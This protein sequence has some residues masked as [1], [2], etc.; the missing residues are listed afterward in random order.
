MLFLA[1]EFVY[2]NIMK[3]YYICILY[4]IE[5][6]V[7]F[8]QLYFIL[9]LI[10]FGK[11]CL[12]SVI[13]TRSTI[14]WRIF[15]RTRVFLYLISR[16]HYPAYLRKHARI[17]EHG[18]QQSAGNESAPSTRGIYHARHNWKGKRTFRNGHSKIVQCNCSRRFPPSP[19]RSAARA[20]AHW[21]LPAATAVRRLLRLKIPD[22]L[23]VRKSGIY[24]FC[25]VFVLF[26]FCTV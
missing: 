2:K 17:S 14:L 1:T 12:A 18:G 3:Y 26:V 5:K 6:N 9:S 25:M 15:Q 10:F 4:K 16:R 20:R 22:K 21:S 11:F 8:L 23:K 19:R 24:R 7:N 13:K